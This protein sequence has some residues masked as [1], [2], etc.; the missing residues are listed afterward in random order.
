MS[1]A[2]APGK[3]LL[4]GAYAVL[5][6]APAVV[7]AV[8]RGA[9]ADSKKPADHVSEELRH[10][11]SANGTNMPSPPH[12]S[13]ASLFEGEKKLGLGAS[14]AGLVAALGVLA[15][16]RGEDLAQT[17]VR[18]TLFEKARAAHAAA[19]NGG[20]GVDVAASVYGGLLAYSITPSHANVEP[21]SCPSALVV[22][23][24]FSG[25][26]AS[27]QSMRARVDAL[28]ETDRTRYQEVMRPL[29]LASIAA[30]AAI[31]R[32]AVDGFV[33]NVRES[34]RA[35]AEL[36]RAADAPIVLP[37]FAELGTLAEDEGAAF[38]GS[39][40]GGGDIAIYVGTR[41]SS[42]AF[43]ERARARGLTAFSFERDTLGLR[44]MD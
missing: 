18:L 23:G 19:Q 14:A 32:G 11:L 21:L 15:A 4:S 30:K 28:K 2:F 10:A 13:V 9:I 39:G 26:S 43:K 6:G 35:L 8:S 1:R 25:A 38:T 5:E 44:R 36:G 17:D 31:A 16:E 42:A 29:T 37:A 40:A 22:E 27:T 34:V 20:S 24:W 7:L 12:V 3:I 33:A 41:P